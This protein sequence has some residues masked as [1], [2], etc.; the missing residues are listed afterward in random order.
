MLTYVTPFKIGIFT[1]TIQ[2]Q[3]CSYHMTQAET[4][5]YLSVEAYKILKDVIIP[6]VI[7][8]YTKR[9]IKDAINDTIERFTIDILNASNTKCHIYMEC[10]GWSQ[11]TTITYSQSQIQKKEVQ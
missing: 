2:C 1:M 3:K 7:Q 9:G 10:H 8:S 6:Y 5:G 11:N 4:I